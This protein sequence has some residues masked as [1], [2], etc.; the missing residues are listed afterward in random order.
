M[1]QLLPQDGPEARS[2]DQLAGLI[3]ACRRCA[4]WAGATQGVPGEGPAHAPLMLVGEQPGDQ[5]DL[6]GHPFVGPAGGVLDRALAEAGVA[7][8]EA[9]VTNAVKHFKNEP[10]GKRRL[11][12]TPD[13][14]EILACRWWLDRERLLVRPRVIVAMGGSAVL[15][16]FGKPMPILKNRGRALQLPDQAQGVITVHPSMILR[17]PG[18][19]AKRE[20]FAAFVRDLK[21]ARA[22]VRDG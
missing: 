5:E 17:I 6:A 15:S 18:A 9:F 8:G 16:V 12:R 14:A 3:Q 4:L 21:A 2:L 13:R 11:H 19:E 7:R 20:A 1:A 22:L 10:R